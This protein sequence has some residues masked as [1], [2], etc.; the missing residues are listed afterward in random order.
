[1]ITLLTLLLG[2]IREYRIQPK[3][4]FLLPET[5]YQVDSLAMAEGYYYLIDMKS[6]QLVKIAEDGILMAS[7]QDQ[8]PVRFTVPMS[9]A[10]GAGRVFVGDLMSLFVF[11]ANDLSFIERLP[12]SNNSFALAVWKDELI[13]STAPFPDR[14]NLIQVFEFKGKKLREF[15]DD[16]CEG[17]AFFPFFDLDSKGYIYAQNT[18]IYELQILDRQGKSVPHSVKIVQ[19]FQYRELPDM[20]KFTKKYGRTKTAALKIRAN[21]SEPVGIAVERDRFVWLCYRNLQENLLTREYFVDVYDLVSGQ[22][23]IQWH[24]TKGRLLKGGEYAY[25]VEDR[26]EGDN[27]YQLFLKGYQVK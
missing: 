21:W 25:F 14:G 6:A 20:K 1:M 8:G 17:R 16:H 19:P 12:T 26:D 10:V 27:D 18:G 24:Q 7:F 4:S 5:L 11:D 3:F 13:A 23:I 9:V 2:L 15:Y 22:K